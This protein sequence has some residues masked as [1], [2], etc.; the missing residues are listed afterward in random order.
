MKFKISS[1]MN[2]KIKSNK[3]PQKTLRFA[4][5]INT[6]GTLKISIF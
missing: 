2:Y 6:I 4:N 5:E 3:L 1:S